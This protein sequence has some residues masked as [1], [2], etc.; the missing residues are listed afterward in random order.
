MPGAGEKIG[1]ISAG[2][3]S[4]PMRILSG[5]AEAAVAASNA[6][7]IAHIFSIRDRRSYMGPPEARRACAKATPS[8][9]GLKNNYND[10]LYSSRTAHHERYRVG[11]GGPA[12]P[13]GAARRDCACE[14][15]LVWRARVP[16]GPCDARAAR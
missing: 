16:P 11:M 14:Q 12:R 9:H 1:V 6:A 4:Q 7:G 15:P 3:S 8:H 5:S 13:H 2:T 10:A